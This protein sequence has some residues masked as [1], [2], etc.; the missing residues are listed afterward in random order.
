MPTNEVNH[1]TTLTLGDDVSGD[2]LERV[3]RH[4]QILD[5]RHKNDTNAPVTDNKP[6]DGDD[7]PSGDDKDDQ[8]DE[9]D[10]Q[11][12]GIAIDSFLEENKTDK[13][14]LLNQLLDDPDTHLT[15]TGK[16]GERKASYADIKSEIDRG[17]SSQARLTK[18]N[19]SEEMK[20]GH[21]LAAAKSGDKG[22][23]KQ[24]FELLKEFAGQEE[25]DDFVD[26]MEKADGKKFDVNKK[27]EEE[28]SE[29]EWEDAF[30]QHVKE[31]VDYQ[32]TLDKM[33]ATLRGSNIPEKIY[34]TYDGNPV[35][36]K[37][38]YDLVAQG[39]AEKAMELFYAKYETLSFEDQ[40]KLDTDP[41]AWGTAFTRVFKSIERAPKTVE[42]ESADQE[43]E[44]PSDLID[45][46]SS[47]SK[48][49]SPIVPPKNSPLKVS[50]QDWAA[51]RERLLAG[52]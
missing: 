24:A 42:P 37:I 9:G 36:R 19:D 12:N 15:L 32:P 44:D 52:Q 35:Q 27:R 33:R 48:G 17:R 10:G 16:R 31:S 3:N 30:P 43:K 39:H 45:S 13:Q 40:L 14:T 47:G 1:K 41:A 28:K 38:M 8:G 50:S 34:D 21:I 23:Q 51:E 46:M 29:Q 11:G 49:R 6:A 22:A 2:L 7:L 26:D 18:I 5:D 25:I 20:F 4:Q